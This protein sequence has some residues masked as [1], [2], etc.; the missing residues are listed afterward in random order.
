MAGQGLRRF[1]RRPLIALDAAT[2]QK[3]WDVNTVDR[4]KPHDYG[5][6]RVVKGK[7]IIGNG[8]RNSACAGTYPYDANTGD[9]AWRFYTVPGNPADGL[10][11]PV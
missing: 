6:P 7:V 2:G 8:V 11:T 4:T 1:V 10:D 5:R 9:L 3:L